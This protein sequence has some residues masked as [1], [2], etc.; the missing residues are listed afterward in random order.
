MALEKPNA[1][2]SVS[3]PASLDGGEGPRQG[4]RGEEPSPK[5]QGPRWH[6]RKMR[7]RGSRAPKSDEKKSRE[8]TAG[9]ARRLFHARR[10]G[11]KEAR[12]CSKPAGT[13]IRAQWRRSARHLRRPRVCARVFS[14]TGPRPKG[15]VQERRG[16]LMPSEKVEPGGKQHSESRRPDSSRCRAHAKAASLSLR[17]GP[18]PLKSNT[19][20]TCHPKLETDSRKG[21][22]EGPTHSKAS[23]SEGGRGGGAKRLSAPG[24]RDPSSWGTSSQSGSSLLRMASSFA[25]TR[26]GP[27]PSISRPPQVTT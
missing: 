22:A 17:F 20:P 26:E 6:E 19:G 27:P 7:A 3:R 2:L 21:A 13:P 11:A 16:G 8:E 12:G 24:G 5:Q 23:L 25:R 10:A 1:S 15:Q 4:S 18:K 9:R 14:E